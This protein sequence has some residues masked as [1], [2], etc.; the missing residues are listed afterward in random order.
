M[1]GDFLWGTLN[2]LARLSPN[3]L[4]ENIV[5]VVILLGCIVVMVG[6]LYTLYLALLVMGIVGRKVLNILG[7]IL[8]WPWY[9]LEYMYYRKRFKGWV[10]DKER[11]PK[12]KEFVATPEQPLCYTCKEPFGGEHGEVR[13]NRVYHSKCLCQKCGR[14]MMPAC[15]GGLMCEGN[16]NNTCKNEILK[17]DCSRV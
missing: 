1:I 12:T 9:F 2:G 13:G 15:G 7:G 5:D 16:N 8:V 10:K 17:E 4:A 6:M 14:I 3:F 11:T